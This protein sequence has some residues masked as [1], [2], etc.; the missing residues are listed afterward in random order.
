MAKLHG[1][2]TF[3]ILFLPHFLMNEPAAAL[4]FFNSTPLLAPQPR[5]AS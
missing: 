4:Y 3:S 5:L 2:A 1:F